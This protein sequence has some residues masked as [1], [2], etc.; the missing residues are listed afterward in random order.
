LGLARAGH[1]LGVPEARTLRRTRWLFLVSTSIV[2]AWAASVCL[3]QRTPGRGARRS[4]T[5]DKSQALA[6]SPA[7]VCLSIDGQG[8]YETLPDAALTSEEKLLVFYRPLNYHVDHDN[9]T[10][11]IHLVQDGQVRARGSKGVLIAKMKMIDE[12]WK[13]R[14]PPAPRYIR[15]LVALKGLR[16]GDY[17]FDI[18]L[19]D[20]LAPGEPTARQTL[21]FK[22][23]PPG[24]RDTSSK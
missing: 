9:S 13:G 21:P 23:V 12:D 2:L 24:T 5:N 22:V 17:E 1:R 8:N 15:S 14:E 10:Y 19:H 20:L 4:E 11:H 18:T 7:V 3:A 16:P 6:M